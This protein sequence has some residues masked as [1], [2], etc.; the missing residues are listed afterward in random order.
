MK[1]FGSTIE[2]GV[3]EGPA[4]EGWKNKYKKNTYA[5]FFG[6]VTS[7]APSIIGK[8][9]GFYGIMESRSGSSVTINPITVDYTDEKDQI[10]L[11]VK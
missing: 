5:W 1:I 3:Y 8:E 10:S 9:M 2:P 6:K 11:L 4:P 7:G